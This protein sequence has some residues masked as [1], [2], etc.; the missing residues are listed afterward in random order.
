M[1]SWIFWIRPSNIQIET[2]TWRPCNLPK[3]LA[4]WK[5][6][7]AVVLNFSIVPVKILR[8]AFVE[9]SIFTR[10]GLSSVHV[11]NTCKH[12]VNCLFL[13]SCTIKF[14]RLSTPN[15]SNRNISVLGY[16]WTIL[17]Q[18]LPVVP[19][20]SVLKLETDILNLHFL[21]SFD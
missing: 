16:I 9:K 19:A 6:S 1:Q 20:L 4:K 17:H 2:V 14:V 5:K 13:L 7:W 18:C 12:F 15:E 21:L 11:F 8:H 10:V 3:L